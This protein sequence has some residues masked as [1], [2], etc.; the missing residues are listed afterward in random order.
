MGG[1][2]LEEK[3]KTGKEKMKRVKKKR[4][5]EINRDGPGAAAPLDKRK[6]TL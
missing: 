3:R 4:T 2:S 1:N 5:P 6:K